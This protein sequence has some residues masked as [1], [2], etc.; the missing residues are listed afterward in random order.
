MAFHTGFYA[1][2]SNVGMN[3]QLNRFYS[4]GA[5]EKPL[6]ERIGREATD[7]G[8]WISLFTEEGEKAEAQE[9]HLKAAVCFRAAQFYALS[10][11]RDSQN[12]EL[13]TL[14]PLTVESRR[15]RS[16]GVT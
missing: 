4:M 16:L 9:D 10:D 15:R 14:L 7:F 1:F 3:Y 12:D 6:L 8:K 5:L 13:R 11:A 2:S